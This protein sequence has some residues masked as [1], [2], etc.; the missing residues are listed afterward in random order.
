MTP[1]I[2]SLTGRAADR[3]TQLALAIVAAHAHEAFR[4]DDQAPCYSEVPL[5]G[6]C[7]V[8]TRATNRSLL[9]VHTRHGYAPV[10]VLAGIGWLSPAEIAEAANLAA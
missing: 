8:V 2:Y 1:S 3:P 4:L 7:A 9:V 6:G 5:T 10:I